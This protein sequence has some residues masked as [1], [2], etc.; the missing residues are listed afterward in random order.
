MRKI[1]RNGVY[2]VMIFPLLT[3]LLVSCGTR[4]PVRVQTRV[5]HGVLVSRIGTLNLGHVPVIFKPSTIHGTVDDR[6]D[7]LIDIIG[8]IRQSEI[9]RR[10]NSSIY[11][12]TLGEGPGEISIWFKDHRCFSIEPDANLRKNGLQSK[13]DTKRGRFVVMGGVGE[14][15]EAGKV[16]DCVWF[17]TR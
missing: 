7:M 2:T 3:T 4:I 15:D 13:I 11:S 10:Y 14:S 9:F 1:G 8:D 6:V 16:R 12:I 17:D 5:E